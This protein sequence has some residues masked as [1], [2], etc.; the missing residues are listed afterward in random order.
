MRDEEPI[1]LYKNVKM[2]KKCVYDNNRLF[3]V[4][5]LL[6]VKAHSSK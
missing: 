5:L 4:K 3:H 6:A 1:L 2:A